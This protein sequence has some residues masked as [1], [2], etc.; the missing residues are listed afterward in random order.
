[1]AK[2]KEEIFYD[3]ASQFLHIPNDKAISKVIIYNIEGAVV[4]VSHS[5][6]SFSISSLDYGIYLIE[7]ET[8]LGLVHKPFV[9]N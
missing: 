9:R 8:E 4:A 2:L 3:S 1:M 7:M 6:K 5:N